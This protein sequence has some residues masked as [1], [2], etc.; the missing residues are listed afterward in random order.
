MS[1]PDPT[2]ANAALSPET[3]AIIE[4]FKGIADELKQS[5]LDAPDLH[6]RAMKKAVYP[7]NVAAPGISAFN[8][9]GQKDYPLP[10]L[11]CEIRAPHQIHPAYHGL[12]REEVELFNLLE[13]GEYQIDLNDGTP[14]RVIVRGRYNDVTEK[15]ERLDID[16]FPRWTN[17]HKSLFPAMRTMLRTMLGE[18]ASGVLSMG[19]ERRLI[20]AKELPVSIGE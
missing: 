16:T 19:Q 17:E 9:R 3:A 8:Q 20:E 14:G 13:P 11:K 2:T 15:L 10:E 7:S 4:G 12:D 18:T 6:A 1:K 5:R